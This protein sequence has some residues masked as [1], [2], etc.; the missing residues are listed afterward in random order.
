[1]EE[2]TSIRTPEQYLG[3]MDDQQ[4]A[5]R[6]QTHRWPQLK[7][8]MRSLPVGYTSKRLPGGELVIFEVCLH[9]CGRVRY[10]RTLPGGWWDMEAKYAYGTLKSK[11]WVTVPSGT[12]LRKGDITANVF[13]GLRGLLTG[14]PFSG[15][16][17]D[18]AAQG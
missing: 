17:S 6:G 7:P 1:M 18:S 2:V 16:G 4:R 11:R 15:E 9:G 12:G 14:V 10:R 3:E 13:N 5:C 8:G